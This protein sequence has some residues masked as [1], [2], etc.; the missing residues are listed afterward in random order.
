MSINYLCF[1]IQKQGAWSYV[2][3]SDNKYNKAK[4]NFLF[5]RE[6][7]FAYSTLTCYLNDC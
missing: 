2:A 4:T 5:T 3:L 1:S 6:F 7:I